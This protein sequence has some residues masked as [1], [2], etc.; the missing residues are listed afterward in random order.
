MGLYGKRYPMERQVAPAQDLGDE[1]YGISE[2][3]GDLF[4]W[5]GRTQ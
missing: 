3:D 2:Q 1:G 5:G 4:L